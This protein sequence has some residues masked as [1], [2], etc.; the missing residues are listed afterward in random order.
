MPHH[1]PTSD[2]NI[3]RYRSFKN[4]GDSGSARTNIRAIWRAKGTAYHH[5]VVCARNPNRCFLS[6]G[7]VI[8]VRSDAWNQW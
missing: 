2:R 1:G 5:D 6:C 3:I 7:S 4:P 8:M